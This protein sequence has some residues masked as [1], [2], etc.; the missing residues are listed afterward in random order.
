MPKLVLQPAPT[1]SKV[2]KVPVPGGETADVT[3]TFRHRT[4]D[5][6]KAW[7]DG[8]EGR[9]DVQAVLDMATGWDLA[10]PF[11]AENVGVLVQ[12]YPASALAVLR[13][14]YD[15]LSAARLGN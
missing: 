12:N 2:V 1:F 5:E 7:G 15:E 4:R 11:D 10:E 8:A 9:S 6:L 3:F 14:Y 13:T